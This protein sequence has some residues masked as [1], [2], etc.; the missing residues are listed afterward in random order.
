LG[1][2]GII[3]EVAAVVVRAAA[4]EHGCGLC[5]EDDNSERRFACGG[6]KIGLL[7]LSS[8][9]SSSPVAGDVAGRSQAFCV[10]EGVVWGAERG[11]MGDAL[12]LR[13]ICRR[14]SWDVGVRGRG[15]LWFG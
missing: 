3:D 7:P 10:L 13:Q 5:K 1:K 11:T 9:S 8:S 12:V 14:G 6:V 2:T 15:N 4:A